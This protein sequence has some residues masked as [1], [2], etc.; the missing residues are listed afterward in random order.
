MCIKVWGLSHLGSFCIQELWYIS[1]R[2]WSLEVTDALCDLS[3]AERGMWRPIAYCHSV[4]FGKTLLVPASLASQDQACLTQL[5]ILYLLFLSMA[6]TCIWYD[7][8][9]MNLYIFL[10]DRLKIIMFAGYI[11]WL[12]Y[13]F[14]R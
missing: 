8:N 13:N 11:T 14:C 1:L 5:I 9:L 2:I 10:S 12:M 3:T 7:N 6:F 4:V